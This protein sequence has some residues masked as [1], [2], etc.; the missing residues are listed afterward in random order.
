MKI[1]H[2]S[3]W[4]L[5]KSL[6][7]FPLLADQKIM[8]DFLLNYISNEQIDAIVI[9]GDVYDRPIPSAEAVRLYDSFLTNAVAKMNV[10]TIV[11]AGNH[12][13]ASRLEFGSALYSGCG[14]HIFGT[15]RQ[16]Q[17]PV[18]LRDEYGEVHFH[19][20]PWLHPAEARAM[21]D[22]TKEQI[23]SFDD[24]YRMLLEQRTKSLNKSVRNVAVA[25]GFFA[26]ISSHAEKDILTSDSEINIGG[27]D[28]ADSSYFSAF[29]YTA[30]G[31]LHAPQRAGAENVRYSGSPLK[32]SLSE[33]HQRKSFTVVELG[34]NSV[35][36]VRQVDIPCTYD[37]RSVCGT[38]DELL[39]PT[40]HENKNFDDYVF[41][42]ITDSSVLHPMEKLRTLFPNL[43]GLR[44]ITNEAS[45]GTP[46]LQAN[47]GPKL[48]MLELFSR[49][50]ADAKGAPIS[51]DKLE[52]LREII[53]K[54][55]VERN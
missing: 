34:A 42:N 21:F 4:H 5:G 3:D 15:A 12:D 54:S 1:L 28:I 45:F 11:I 18:I 20:I 48:T 27:M 17:P 26:G 14:Y 2:T 23:K 40:Y 55:E 9:A 31:H 32:Y 53:E 33:E 25:H 51:E 24:A 13:S 50:Y 22:E 44:F 35:T 29:E 37:V 30:L 39:E 7:D 36:E 49:F 46:I 38:F 43:L 8:L 16:S 6:Y 41:A 10:P 47:S 19:P 52:F